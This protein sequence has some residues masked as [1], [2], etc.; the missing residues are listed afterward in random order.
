MNI[1]E[2]TTYITSIKILEHP[3]NGT[4]CYCYFH[5]GSTGKTI[6]PRAGLNPNTGTMP[7]LFQDK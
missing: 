6:F 1:L 4:Y 2:K 3:H 5:T 7:T